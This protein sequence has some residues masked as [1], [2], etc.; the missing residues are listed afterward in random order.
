MSQL[1]EPSVHANTVTAAPPATQFNH[2]HVSGANDL[3]NNLVLHWQ[4]CDC[5]YCS[6]L[7]PLLLA[8]SFPR[9]LLPIRLARP[10]C[11]HPRLRPQ[12]PRLV[13]PPYLAFTPRPKRKT[14]ANFI[15]RPH[16]R[17]STL[18]TSLS[19]AATSTH[20]SH[21]PSHHQDRSRG[22][23]RYVTA[24]GC[25]FNLTDALPHPRLCLLHSFLGFHPRLAFAHTSP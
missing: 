11:P 19:P 17:L 2:L 20:L 23:R 18:W 21:T 10:R 12:H 6:R 24:T 4:V 8:D 5:H 16:P 22:Q 25:S 7:I 1:A 9:S 15:C 13:P 14:E 3:A